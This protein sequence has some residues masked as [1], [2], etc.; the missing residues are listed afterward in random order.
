M[1]ALLQKGLRVFFLE[2]RRFPTIIYEWFRNFP[3][4]GNTFWLTLVEAAVTLSKVSRHLKLA[5]NVQLL[6]LWCCHS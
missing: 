4:C 3:I 1:T 2:I 5:G 6:L